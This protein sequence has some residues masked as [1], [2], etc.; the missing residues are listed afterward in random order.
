[1]KKN[2]C[3]WWRRRT[4]RYVFANYDSSVNN[5]FF[6]CSFNNKNICIIMNLLWYDI[7]NFKFLWPLQLIFCYAPV[8]QK[9]ILRD[10]HLY[11]FIKNNFERS[12]N[13]GGF[14]RLL[15]YLDILTIVVIAIEYNNH[16]SSEMFLYLSYTS[17]SNSEESIIL[18][19]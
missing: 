10:W 15:N 3:C 17:V 16:V 4:K 6:H 2:C 8:R 14:S 11:T 12:R 7:D 18:L 1:M 5:W 19:P 13:C 9:L